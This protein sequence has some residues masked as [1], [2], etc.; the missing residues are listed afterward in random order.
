MSSGL[1]DSAGN[2]R[3]PFQPAGGVWVWG[4]VKKAT[5]M[6]R[7]QW[8]GPGLGVKVRAKVAGDE[9]A[10]NERDSRRGAWPPVGGVVSRSPVIGSWMSACEM[11]ALYPVAGMAWPRVPVVVRC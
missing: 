3:V 1:G 9:V 8:G 4:E 7:G 10:V 11:K 6:T 2:V 5:A